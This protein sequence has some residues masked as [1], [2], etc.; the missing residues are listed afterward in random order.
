MVVPGHL[1]KTTFK[2]RQRMRDKIERD[3]ER[4]RRTIQNYAIRPGQNPAIIGLMILVLVIMG[5]MLVGRVKTIATQPS[6]PTREMRAEKELHALRIALE[7]FNQDC[8]RYPTVEEGLKALIINPGVKSWGGYYVTLIKPD[9]WRTPYAY[10]VTSNS[11]ELLSYGPD[12]VRGTADDIQAPEPTPEE[13][14]P[15]GRKTKSEV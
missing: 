14:D 3:A 1:R 15:R 7:R 8:G 11:V 13:I 10:N 12:R 6:R 5:G 4:E 2:D 9:P